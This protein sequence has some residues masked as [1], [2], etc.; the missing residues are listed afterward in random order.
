MVDPDRVFE[1]FDAERL[2]SDDGT[3][4]FEIRAFF[5]RYQRVLRAVELRRR[6]GVG[7]D[8]RSCNKKD[9]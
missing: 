5:G 1:P 2:S 8:G 3:F 4:N 6:S 7:V 9:A